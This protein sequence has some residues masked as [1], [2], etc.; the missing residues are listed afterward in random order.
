MVFQANDGYSGKYCSKCDKIYIDIQYKWC[1]S[2]QLNYLKKFT[3]QNEEIDNF[4]QEMQSKINQP[5]DV[6]FEWIPYNQLNYIKGINKDNF[7]TVYLA[8]WKDGPLNWNT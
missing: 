6:V 7:A 3:S 1:K 5:A 8:I 4:I 2:C